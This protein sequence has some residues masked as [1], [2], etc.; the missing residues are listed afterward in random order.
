MRRV[1]R[2]GEDRIKVRGFDD[3]MVFRAGCCHPI[4]GEKIVGYITRGRG[5]SVHA[6]NCPNV[7]N[8]LYDPDRRIDVVW[9]KGADD[10]RYIV[11]LSIQV[12]DRRGLLADVTSKIAGIN[13]N[14]RNVEATT[15]DDHRGRID[16]TV[17][18]QDVKHLEKV[19]K[20]LRRVTGVLEIERASG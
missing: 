16:V 1:L 6:A 18:I 7:L 10:A 8:L 4:R 15:G 12:E 2:P 14:I 9:D 20:S 5:V 19:I 3:L 13:T 11:R 17:E